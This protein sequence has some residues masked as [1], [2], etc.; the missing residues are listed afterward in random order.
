MLIG[1]ISDT[2]GHV[3][4]AQRA[5]RML[6]Q[7]SPA[8]VLHCGDIGTA[9]IVELFAAWPS[10]YVLGNTDEDAEPLR[11]AVDSAG[12]TWHGRFGE[13]ELGGRKIALLHG[14]DRR[15]LQ[16]AITSGVYDLICSGHSHVPETCQVGKTLV[17]NPGAL[18]RAQR[19][20]I[21]IVDLATMRATHVAV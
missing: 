21:A 5:A 13:V 17:L 7:F 1:V 20:T 8:A 9:E 14:D 19:H 16:D 4:N 10:H 12:Q 18:F 3:E 15:R 6:E 11:K 2:H